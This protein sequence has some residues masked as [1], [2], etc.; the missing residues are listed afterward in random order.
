MQEI[1]LQ[2]QLPISKG[3]K[4]NAIKTWGFSRIKHISGFMNP[5]P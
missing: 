1:L 3:K 4:I 5:L 2:N